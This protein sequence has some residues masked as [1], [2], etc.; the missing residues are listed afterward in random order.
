L[1]FCR[2]CQTSKKNNLP[3]IMGGEMTGNKSKDNITNSKMFIVFVSP[4]ILCQH[5]VKRKKGVVLFWKITKPK[6]LRLPPKR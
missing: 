2:N 1:Y 5:Q 6:E 4:Y 3:V